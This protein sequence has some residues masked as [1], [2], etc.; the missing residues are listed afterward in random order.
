MKKIITLILFSLLVLPSFAENIQLKSGKTIEG[1]II[2]KTNSYIKV[3]TSLEIPITYYFDDIETIYENTN[4]AKKILI[5]NKDSKE[6]S[7]VERK[8][9][10]IS[11]N[12]IIQVYQCENYKQ[13]Q[14]VVHDFC[15]QKFIDDSKSRRSGMPAIEHKK[16]YPKFKTWKKYGIYPKQLNIKNIK[17]ND[18]NNRALITYHYKEKG[19]VAKNIE[20]SKIDIDIKYDIGL[21]KQKEFW[22]IDTAELVQNVT[23]YTQRNDSDTENDCFKKAQKIGIKGSKYQQS[24]QFNKALSY[25]QKALNTLKDCYPLSK[26]NSR[27]VTGLYGSLYLGMASMHIVLGEEEKGIKICKEAV[28]KFPRMANAYYNIMVGAYIKLGKTQEAIIFCKTS[29]KNNPND[30]LPYSTL[31]KL[32][33]RLGDYKKAKNNLQKAFDLSSKKGEISISQDIKRILNTIP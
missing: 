4:H 6:F 32:Y 13:Y 24:S 12:F 17:F 15:S 9:F 26:T 19:L 20:D 2:E 5:N 8:I 7:K 27:K 23:E 28:N 3:D 30:W 22:K 11:K 10:T 33:Y 25:Y 14:Q 29:I 21:I 1:K 18:K 31:G 16:Y